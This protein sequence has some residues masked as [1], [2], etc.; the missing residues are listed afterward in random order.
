MAARGNARRIA[1][2]AAGKLGFAKSVFT[3]TGDEWDTLIAG[4]PFRDAT[5]G[6]H[7]H[8]AV[9]AAT[10]SDA[11]IDKIRGHAVE[12]EGFEVIDDVAYLHT[13]HGFGT[14]KLAIRF[15]RDIGV[16]NTARNWNTVTRL[17]ELLR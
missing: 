7:L 15:D 14:S 8:A 6:A 11:A 17:G 2:I 4:N 16:E 3:R 5:S 10:P 13:P 9:L 1:Q 12:G